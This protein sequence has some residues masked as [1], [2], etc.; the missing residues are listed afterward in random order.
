MFKPR[1]ALAKGCVLP[2][3]LWVVEQL[4]GNTE[5]A[6]LSVTHYHYCIQTDFFLNF[7]FSKNIPV[8]IFIVYRDVYFL[9][10]IF[11]Y[12]FYLY[13]IKIWGN[14][15]VCV[16]SADIRNFRYAKDD[17]ITIVWFLQPLLG[18][19]LPLQPHGTHSW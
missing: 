10:L 4:P 5:S 7:V 15:L 17:K 12:I 11:S 9:N 6:D 18:K 8:T 3:L 16:F 1:T 19:G 2:G 14:C 13:R